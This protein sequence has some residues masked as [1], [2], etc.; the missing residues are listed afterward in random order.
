[1]SRTMV[2]L[3]VLL[4]LSVAV[5]L[6]LG[7][8]FFRLYLRAIPPIALNDF[9]RQSAR[10]AYLLYGAGV[11]LVLFAWTLLGMLAGKTMRS[12]PKPIPNP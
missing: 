5:G 7:E 1:M 12:K 4:V 8:W 3:I 6:L 11:G 9:N 10:I 2:I